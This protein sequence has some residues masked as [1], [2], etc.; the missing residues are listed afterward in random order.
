MMQKGRNPSGKGAGRTEHV[1]MLEKYLEF[2]GTLWVVAGACD[3]AGVKDLWN[4]NT[5]SL[6]M[7]CLA[8]KVLPVE[9]S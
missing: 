8:M 9:I 3:D 2:V 7:M 5:I 1:N 4:G 6:L